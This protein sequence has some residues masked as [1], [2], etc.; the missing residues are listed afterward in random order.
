MP[1]VK[2]YVDALN[3]FLLRTHA[4]RQNNVLIIDEAQN[5]SAGVLEQLRL[6]TNLETNERKL[7]QIILIGQPELR[8]MLARPDMQ[9]LAQRVIARYHLEALTEGET[10]HYVSHRLTVAGMRQANPFDRRAMRRIYRYSRGVPRRINLLCDRALLGAYANSKA[11]VD[12]RHPRQGGRGSAGRHRLRP[13]P[14]RALRACGARGHR[15]GGGRAAGRQRSASRSIAARAARRAP[16]RPR[17]RARPQTAVAAAPAAAPAAPEPA[18]AAG[19][20]EA[21]ELRPA[22][23]LCVARRRRAGGVA[24]AGT[25]VEHRA[26]QRRSLRGGREG[27]RSAAT[28]PAMRRWR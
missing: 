14:P 13:D 22:Q 24:A 23:G 28:A 27:S 5:L 26:G 11:V 25:R 3:E 7:L 8:A 2:D 9:Q 4:V 19:A 1:T 12:G 18:A 16:L 15:A 6:L 21:G 10:A 20:R 17:T